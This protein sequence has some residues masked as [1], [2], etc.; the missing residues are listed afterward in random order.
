MLPLLGAL[1][2][3]SRAEATRLIVRLVPG[4]NQTLLLL[5]DESSHLHATHLERPGLTP[6]QAEILA[7]I[8]KGKTNLDISRIL[9]LRVR[10]VEKQMEHALEKLG[11][12]TR[13][14]AV[15]RFA[16]AL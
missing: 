13:A 16:T 10:T 5:D 8:A 2:T 11:V 9:G 14:A 7:W 4:L 3:L 12:E 1:P 15:A 6:R